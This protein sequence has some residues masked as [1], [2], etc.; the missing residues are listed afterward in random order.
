MTGA[1]DSKFCM[2]VRMYVCMLRFEHYYYFGGSMLEKYDDILTVK[3]L[4]EVL[5]IGRKLAYSLL[6]NG[7]IESRKIGRIYR[8]PKASVIKYLTCR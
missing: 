2:Y 6:Q 8:I 7:E 1:D 4:C 3:E 5:H